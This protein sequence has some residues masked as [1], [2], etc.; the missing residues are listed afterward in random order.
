MTFK[1]RWSYYIIPAVSLLSFLALAASVGVSMTILFQ[2]GSGSWEETKI[3]FVAIN[4]VLSLAF[5]GIGVF[6]WLIQPYLRFFFRVRF[7][8][9]EI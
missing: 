3:E 8:Y 1:A 4:M 6:L 9:Q 2:D 7:Y 5:V